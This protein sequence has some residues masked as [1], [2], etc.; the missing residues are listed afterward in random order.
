M[1]SSDR[2][3]DAALAG[4]DDEVEAMLQRDPDAPRSSIHVAAA[5]GDMEAFAALLRADR[6]LADRRGGRREWTPL[7]YLCCSRYG[8]RDPQ[9]TAARIEI[10]RHLLR[11]VDVNAVGRE[12][13][14]E[15][16]EWRPLAGAAGPLASLELVRLLVWS[17]ASIGGTN[18]VLSH[19]VR[20]GDIEILRFLLG[21][22]PRDWYQL[23]W[24]AHV[25][26]HVERIDMARLI[27][28]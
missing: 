16:R 5:L 19:A 9:R 1:D 26:V 20:G 15:D 2:L 23:I 24:A 6:T 17:G 3:I 10:A 22:S 18:E 7:L 25:S 21:L 27:A 13:G 11:R 14:Y 12:P 28:A 4:Q 8:R